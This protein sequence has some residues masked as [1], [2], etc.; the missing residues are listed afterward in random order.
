MWPFHQSFFLSLGL[1]GALL[2]QR[3]EAGK[4]GTPLFD[5]CSLSF[6]PRYDDSLSNNLV[7]QDPFWDYY[8][9]YWIGTNENFAPDGSPRP[10][11]LYNTKTKQGIPYSTDVPFLTFANRS[12]DG[13][14]YYHHVAIVYDPANEEFC[15]QQLEGDQANVIGNGTCGINGHA[16]AV[17]ILGTSTYE[18]DSSV[19]IF[20][21]T[22]GQGRGPALL[23]TSFAKPVDDHTIFFSAGNVGELL[24]SHSQQLT[25]RDRDELSGVASFVLFQGDDG[26]TWHMQ[27]KQRRV[28]EEE[29]LQELEQAYESSNV[30]EEDRLTTPLVGP[31]LRTW[32]CPIDE[33]TWCAAGDPNTQRCPNNVSP[34]QE[35]DAPMR[36]GAV[37]GFSILGI[38]VVAVIGYVVWASEMKK[39][40]ARYK[41]LFV[42]RIAKEVEMNRRGSVGPSEDELIAAFK[43]VDTSDDGYIEKDELKAFLSNGK[44]EIDNKD[45]DAL[46]ASMDLKGRGRVN[47]L[48]FCAYLASCDSEGLATK[49]SGEER[50]NAIARQLSA[51]Q[52]DA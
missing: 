31:C 44:I 22:N 21:W 32:D 49:G 23:N 48:D 2:S 37:V 14:R 9:G 15:D 34:Y 40:K 33:A 8:T 5:P 1:I 36:T 4:C 35:P 38:A 25:T 18:K 28:T 20:W 29:W 10:P 26:I 47:F 43:S 17:D 30:L 39:K 52:V 27:Y 50:V 13:T 7:D 51:K 16:A 19:G 12:V 11:S 42:E 45:F 6:D 46:F 41:R 24:W 3:G